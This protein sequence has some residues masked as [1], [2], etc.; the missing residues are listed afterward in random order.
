LS[1]VPGGSGNQAVGDFAMALGR[2]TVVT[3]SGSF[4][5]A[6]GS[7]ATAATSATANEFAVA[8]TGGVKFVTS[9]DLTSGN[10][11]RLSAGGGSWACTSDWQ[12]KTAFARVDPQ[13]VLAKV[14]ALP[15]T[16]WRFITQPEGS[17]HIGPMAQDFRTLFGLGTDD[18]TITQV[19]I[20]GVTLAAIQGLHQTLQQTEQATTT[21]LKRLE[22]QVERRRAV[23]DPRVQAVAKDLARVKAQLGLQ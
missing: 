7:A 3:P 21:K 13:S 6:D 18:R 8:A 15:L 9:R 23:K 12:A 11:C 5:F 16:S 4:L 17:R 20:D 22:R 19:D 2:Q 1:T 14:L 10:G